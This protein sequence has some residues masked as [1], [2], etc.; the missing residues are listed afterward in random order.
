M[1]VSGVV[2]MVDIEMLAEAADGPT[3]QALLEDYE[4][5]LHARWDGPLPHDPHADTDTS[6]MGAGL[7]PPDGL[8]LV[9]RVEGTPAGCVGLRTLTPGTGEMK[10]M[11]VRPPFR[12]RGL[13]RRLLI[14]VED[15]ARGLSLTRL[16]LDTMDDFVEALALYT[17]AGYR[18]I[19]PY[20]TNP[21][22]RHW[23]E[24]T[25]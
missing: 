22:V 23:L 20:T 9:A 18:E 1:I 12:G 10:R 17:S 6:D 8:F 5:E 11:F 25:L 16:R 19:A 14:T 21:Y 4:R 13:G 24:K 3:A 2:H 7:V 15:A